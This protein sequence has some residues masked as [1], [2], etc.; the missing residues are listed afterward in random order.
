MTEKDHTNCPRCRSEGRPVK[1]ITLQSLLR[2]EQRDR[3]GSHEW[4]FC[5]TPGCDVVYFRAD[6]DGE[7]FTKHDLTVRVG[8]KET[9]APRPVCYCFE[10]TVEEIDEEIARTGRTTVLDDIRTRMKVACWCETTSPMGSCCLATV[11]RF[12]KAAQARAGNTSP[13]ADTEPEEDC[14]A[15]A[16]RPPVTST[17]SWSGLA[18]GGAL[19]SAA[20]SSACCWLPLLLLAFGASAAGVAGFFETWR[21]W[22]LGGAGVLLGLGFYFAYFKRQ[23][24]A[25]GSACATP[26][27]NLRRLNRIILWIA[28]LFIAAFAFFP[29]YL[30]TILGNNKEPVPI[31]ENPDTMTLTIEGMTCESCAITLEKRLL[32]VPD[33]G[34]ARVDYLSRRAIIRPIDGQSISFEEISRTV[35]TAGYTSKRNE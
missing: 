27:P 10:H 20:L 24:C 21:P 28:T 30:G 13:A 8:I 31:T 32:Q 19:L 35:K 5:E 2:E 11:T 9:T 12:V 18:T 16:H 25:P 29:N 15:T 23:T 34:N 1:A 33:V 14:C 4:R 17:R 26:N 3:I 22:F 6:G 7:R